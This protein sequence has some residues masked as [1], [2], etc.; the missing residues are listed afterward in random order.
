MNRKK[1]VLAF[2]AALIPTAQIWILP[3]MKQIELNGQC[4]FKFMTS[5]EVTINEIYEADVVIC[6]RGAAPNELQIIELCKL[7]NKYIIYFL[8]DHLLDVPEKINN[9]FYYLSIRDTVKKLI[10]KSD[11]LWVT[12]DNLRMSYSDLSNYIVVTDPPALLLGENTV[13]HQKNRN[14][15]ILIGYSG[16]KDHE[17]ILE[18]IIEEPIRI[19]L[20]KYRDKIAFEFIGAKPSFVDT[21]NLN[22]IPYTHSFDE[23]INTLKARNWDIGIA[24]LENS[25]FNSCKS[26]IKFLDYGAIGAAG[27]YSNVEP[28][29][30]VVVNGNNGILTNNTTDDWVKALSYLIDIPDARDYIQWQAYNLLKT[31]HNLELISE[32]IKSKILKL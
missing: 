7:L 6:I 10:I 3:P 24:P 28:Y 16:G 13:F 21:L 18:Q 8:D 19:I 14:N 9:Y 30:R 11:C 23:Y 25:Y 22:Y 20:D 27:I 17:C 2:C 5:N 29:T 1:K 32:I 4:D 12:N 15:K 26:F 31:R